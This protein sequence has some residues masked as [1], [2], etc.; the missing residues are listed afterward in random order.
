MNRLKIS[1]VTPVYS[2]AQY[3][4]N[5]LEELKKVRTTWEDKNAP[6]ILAEAIFVDDAAIDNSPELLDSF[7]K[8]YDW[9]KVIHLSR[10][11]GQHPATIAGVLHSS[12]DWIVTLD[13][14]LQHPPANINR[15]LEKVAENGCDI[16]YANPEGAVHEK[17]IRDYGSR[18]YKRLL[19][20][21]SGIKS[22]PMFN[23]YRL[24]R[25][26]IA[27]AAASVCAHD[28]YF[29]I[30]L[31]WFT[32]RY[33]VVSMPLKDQRMILGFSS[34]YN[35]K[36]LLSHARRML[37]SSQARFLRWI[38]LLGLLALGLSLILG[39]IFLVQKLIAPDSIDVQGWTSLIL[40]ILFFGGLTS[41]LLGVLLEYTGVLLLQSH[42]KPLFFTVER[43]SDAV[44]KDYFKT[45]AKDDSDA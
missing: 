32:E 24:I 25:G 42:G 44:L 16:V 23:S 22:I 4:N 31:S 27:R 11:F 43:H 10:N 17:L 3:L 8:H 7:A 29:D 30:A 19:A 41:L 5:L 12:G 38:A 35:I 37:I 18:L 15:L 9:V 21:V 20:L 13:E 36:G 14:D 26:P 34:G 1:T 6:L 45:G 33:E 40:T 2:G 28:T 39:T